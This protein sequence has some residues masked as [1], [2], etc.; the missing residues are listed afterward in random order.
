MTP[1]ENKVRLSVVL[2]S[3][4][5]LALQLL[6][7]RILSV[8]FWQHLVY[9]VITMALLGMVAAGTAL[10]TCPALRRLDAWTLQRVSLAGFSLS[11]VGGMAAVGYLARSLDTFAFSFGNL[12]DIFKVTA[13]Y[14]IVMVPFFFFGLSVSSAFMHYKDK[15]GSFY[16]CNLVG[17]AAGCFVFLALLRP[18]GAPGLLML[19][20]IMALL[21]EF[22]LA[23]H[24]QTLKA[25]GGAGIAILF[26]FTGKF[27]HFSPERNKQFWTYFSYPRVEHTEWNAVSRIDVVSDAGFP[28]AGQVK[29]ILIDG[30]AQAPIYP[31]KLADLDPAQPATTPRNFPFMLSPGPVERA[32]VI[33]AG[34]GGEVVTAYWRQAKHIDAVEINPGTFR[35]IKDYFADALDGLFSKPSVHLHLEDGRSFVRRSALK[36][37]VILIHAVDS[38]T[39]AAAGAYVMS[40][41]YLYTLEAFTDYI[42]HLDGPGILQVSRWHYPQ[43]PRETLRA[44]I[45]AYEA[46]AGV[47][48]R[49]PSAQLMVIAQTG[50]GPLAHLLV[51]KEPF[52]AARAEPLL[53]VIGKTDAYEILYDPRVGSVGDPANPFYR[54]VSVRAQ[55]RV[56]AY[57][58][59]YPFNVRP[60][61]DDK[62]FF[63]L[64]GRLRHLWSPVKDDSVY[65]NSI[66]GRWPFAMLASLVLTTGVLSVLL[67]GWPLI[68][69]RTDETGLREQWPL[70][71]LFACLGI[72]FMSLEMFYI[73]KSVLLLGH[74]V[75]AMAWTIPL[76]LVGAGVGSHCVDRAYAGSKG[77]LGA[78]AVWVVSMSVMLAIPWTSNILLMLPLAAKFIVLSAIILPAGILL[79]MPFPYALKNNTSVAFVPV[80]W[81][82]NG[83]FSVLASVGSVV[84]A[85]FA[86]YA[87]LLAVSFA[88]YCVA[89]YLLVHRL[90]AAYVSTRKTGMIAA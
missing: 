70:V 23:G 10:A 52:D 53:A 39:A 67:M 87:A 14:L 76:L 79:G 27:L 61:T 36:Y 5:M 54:Y 21:P 57:H 4:L 42:R 46:L 74:P 83:G 58:R 72:G 48:I 73:Q 77:T 34:G 60:V 62:P 78:L 45:T 41:S 43:M 37:G 16:L 19:L 29:H 3:A 84:V 26:F 88:V 28:V 85:I 89:C 22:F 9:F 51:A 59:D 25:C 7:T 8:V 65:F 12:A 17:T 69:L 31:L 49:D 35:V 56:D 38:L 63:F 47:G 1:V 50:P 11:A 81:A 15:A 80:A 68:R 82:I 66:M 64:Y 55:G 18:L 33:G 75:Y 71:A 30:D 6:E 24:G 90:K 13:S 86:G 44:F 32:L 20:A 40:E 2:I